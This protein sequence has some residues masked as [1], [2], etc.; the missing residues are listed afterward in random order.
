MLKDVEKEN[1]LIRNRRDENERA[2]ELLEEEV[3]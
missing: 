2:R 3:L 1:I